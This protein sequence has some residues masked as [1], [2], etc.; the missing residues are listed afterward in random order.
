M[1]RFSLRG[2]PRQEGRVFVVTGANSGLG[3]ETTRA[4]AGLGATV[5]AGCR[6]PERGRAAHADTGGDVRV[7]RLDLASLASVRAFA[8][9]VAARHEAVDVLINNAGVMA[10]P[11][12][13]TQDGFEAQLGTN[14][15]G[16]FALSGLLLPAL[17]RSR[18]PRVVTVSSTTHWG[19]RMRWDDLMGE[20]RYSPWGAYAQ[21][22][23]ANLLFTLE[24]D[25]R[26]RAAGAALIAAAAHP[27]YAATNLQ[28]RG[29]E[30]HGDRLGAALMA[31]GNK[32][33]AQ[34]AA[35]GAL[36]SLCAALHADVRGGDY[37]GPAVLEMWGPPAAARRS[38]A[39]RDADAAARLWRL[40]E[41]LTGVRVAI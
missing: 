37:F 7:E 4:L 1:T 30:A 26:A 24:L 16:H 19:G 39:A 14:H 6:D 38:R 3:L 2:A 21:S 27:G 23:L 29:P 8:E 5:V 15:L 41:E 35:G 40:S 25:R 10:V 22:K 31:L 12:G 18:A 33:A 11:R 17:R 36:P 20:R 32:V 13:L 9:T 34:S 28:R